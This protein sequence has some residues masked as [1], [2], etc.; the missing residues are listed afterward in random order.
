MKMKT[1]GG[2]S[3]LNKWYYS[4]LCGSI[5]M[6]AHS[7]STVLSVSVI[8]SCV[9]AHSFTC[10]E[11]T[12]LMVDACIRIWAISELMDDPCNV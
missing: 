7:L 5:H 6:L 3:L 9:S 12:V 4:K 2:F 1:L 8:V 11:L 10:L